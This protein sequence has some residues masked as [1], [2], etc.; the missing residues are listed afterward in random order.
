MFNAI[1]LTQDNKRTRAELTQLDEAQL[2]EGDVD[3]RVEY[4]TLNYKDA[5]AITGR[6]AIAPSC[7][8]RASPCKAN[9]GPAWSIPSAAIRWPTPARRPAG[10]AQVPTSRP[11]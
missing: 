4:S 6:G 7:R 2:P 10:M 9:A 5:L 1:L 8:R 11:R 3:V